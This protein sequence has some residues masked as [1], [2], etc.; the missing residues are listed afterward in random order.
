MAKKVT[1]RRGARREGRA[2]G[3][4]LEIALTSLTAVRADLSPIFV[5]QFS[6]LAERLTR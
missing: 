5:L 3:I 2:G 1:G 4:K 6:L